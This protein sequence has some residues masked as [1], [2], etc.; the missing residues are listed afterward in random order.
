MDY[1]QTALGEEEPAPVPKKKGVQFHRRESVEQVQR[2]SRYSMYDPEEVIAY[3]GDTD[4]HRLRKE[5]LKAAV[6]DWQM[7][8]RQSDNFTFTTLGIADKVGEGRA[9]KKEIRYKSRNAVLD[10]Q[11]LQEAEGLKDDELL[12]DIYRFTTLKAKEK[13]KQEA[14][15]VAEEVQKF[16][17]S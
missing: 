15:E 17:E 8:R 14:L 2:I 11:D 1:E 6:V 12:A 7:G 10:E 16:Q 3:W 4:E 13:A 5:E 9:M